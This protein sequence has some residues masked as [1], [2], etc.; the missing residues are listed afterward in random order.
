MN[1]D[2]LEGDRGPEDSHSAIATEMG[3]RFGRQVKI[4]IFDD[5]R[6]GNNLFG[7]KSTLREML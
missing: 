3:F 5:N 6:F 2:G 4:K 1:I 7:N